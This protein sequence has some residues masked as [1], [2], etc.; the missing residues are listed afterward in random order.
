MAGKRPDRATL[1]YTQRCQEAF[2]DVP[3]IEVMVK[4]GDSVEVTAYAT[5]GADVTFYSGELI[6]RERALRLAGRK[7][8]ILCTGSIYMLGELRGGSPIGQ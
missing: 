8:L 6:W 3:V 7:D 4:P 1:V 2:K 5:P